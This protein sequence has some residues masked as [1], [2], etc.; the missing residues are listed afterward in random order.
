MSI[1]NQFPSKYDPEHQLESLKLICKKFAPVIYKDQAL[2]LQ[3]LRSELKKAVHQAL[4]C[5]LEDC[6]NNP[7]KTF[8][9]NKRRSLKEQIDQLVSKCLSLLTIEHLMDLAR[10]MEIERRLKDEK[11]RKQLL[12]ELDQEEPSIVEDKVSINLDESSSKDHKIGQFLLG[13]FDNDIS[14]DSPVDSSNELNYGE[15]LRDEHDS[16]DKCNDLLE[17]DLGSSPPINNDL[18]VLR[19]LFALAGETLNPDDAKGEGDF[20][21]L[22][23]QELSFESQTNFGKEFLPSNPRELINWMEFIDIATS[24]RL[25]NLSH[26]LNIELLRA[27]IVNTL[28]PVNLLDAAIRGQLET[29]PVPSNLLRLRLPAP[30][31]SLEDSMEITC[32]LFRTSELEFDAPLLRRCRSQ[33]KH[34]RRD[35]LRM[36][37]QQRHWQSRSVAKEARLLWWQKPLENL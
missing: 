6:E 5:L 34:H 1:K 33:L 27:G 37:L 28:L 11:A 24:R 15:E 30:N 32:L 17:E 25:R 18:E 14:L 20:E 35:L 3:L 36:A 12:R 8:P 19:S 7:L 21:N 2:Y 9:E 4:F 16:K 26:T 22:N 31:G 23:Q 29:Q 10:Q 13:R